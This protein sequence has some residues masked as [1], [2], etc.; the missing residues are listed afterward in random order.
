MVSEPKSYIVSAACPM[1]VTPGELSG[2]GFERSDRRVLIHMTT[3]PRSREMKEMFFALVVQHLG[4]HSG[5]LPEDVMISA[6]ENGHA[7]RSVGHGRAQFL[8]ARL[9]L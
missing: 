7:D 6:V 8:R 5:I 4:E 3:R 1:P 2:L 9:E